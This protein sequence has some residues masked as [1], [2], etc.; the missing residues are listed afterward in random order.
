MY[1]MHYPALCLFAALSPFA[2]TSWVHILF[3]SAAVI[4]VIA[5]MTPVCEWL[6]DALRRALTPT[7]PPRI[8]PVPTHSRFGLGVNEPARRLR[9]SL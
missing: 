4:I 2:P 6:K 5:L 8:A 7:P 1:A 9:K 3:I